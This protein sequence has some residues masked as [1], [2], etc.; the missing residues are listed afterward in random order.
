[1][2]K[3]SDRDKEINDKHVFRVIH[4]R[5]PRILNSTKHFINLD[6]LIKEKLRTFAHPECLSNRQICKGRHGK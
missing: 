4:S 2:K 6:T 5:F 3:F 1:M